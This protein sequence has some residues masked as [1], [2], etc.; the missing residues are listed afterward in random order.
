[1]RAASL[2]NPRNL[3]RLVGHGLIPRV[4]ENMLDA[5]VELDGLEHVLHDARDE[6]VADE[7]HQVARVEETAALAQLPEGTAF[8]QSSTTSS[9]PLLLA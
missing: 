6:A 1:M 9:M 7:A 5:K 3:M 4:V 2:F 8:A